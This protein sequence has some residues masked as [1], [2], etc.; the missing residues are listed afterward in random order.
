M[1]A[2]IRIFIDRVHRILKNKG[3][4]TMLQSILYRIQHAVF[5]RK[6]A[7][8]QAPGT[9]RLKQAAQFRFR[10]P[11]IGVLLPGNSF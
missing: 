11:G 8:K 7:N 3:R 6:A 1:L 4:V 5:G 9:K 10:K 2:V